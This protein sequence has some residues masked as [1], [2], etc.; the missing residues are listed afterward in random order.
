MTKPVMFTNPD[1]RGKKPSST[2]NWPKNMR[3][4]TAF[5]TAEITGAGALQ[6]KSVP[7]FIYALV[8]HY[9]KILLTS[10]TH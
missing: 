6:N 3:N 10:V 5:V 1:G 4:A 2:R 7:L 8:L 9:K